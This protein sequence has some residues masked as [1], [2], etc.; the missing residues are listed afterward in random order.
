[1]LDR[2]RDLL[3]RWAVPMLTPFLAEGLVQACSG[4][5]GQELADIIGARFFE[6]L[7]EGEGDRRRQPHQRF[8]KV[9]EG[10]AAMP[11]GRLVRRVVQ[12]AHAAPHEYHLGGELGDECRLRV[13]HL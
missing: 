4:E 3:P 2:L 10:H 9:F 8:H 6:I 13:A 7:V 11:C 1:M 5:G 12:E